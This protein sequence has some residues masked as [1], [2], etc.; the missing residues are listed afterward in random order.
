MNLRQ[1]L[2]IPLAFA[3]AWVLCYPF[4]IRLIS[5]RWITAWNDVASVAREIE[6]RFVPH[7]GLTVDA[8]QRW[9]E[10]K[11]VQTDPSELQGSSHSQ[12]DAWGNPYQVTERFH[13]NG[14]RYFGI[15]SFGQDGVSFTGGDDADDINSWSE[16]PIA[17]YQ[18]EAKLESLIYRLK[19]TIPWAGIFYAVM[20][21]LLRARS[22]QNHAM[23]S[24]PPS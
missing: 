24:E 10:G 3:L 7:R 11:T 22:K 18:G 6:M 4:T 16:N 9:T 1:L 5:Y 20:F 23:H 15:Y 17:H 2:A 13:E 21:A 8:I 12:T 19:C 14:Q